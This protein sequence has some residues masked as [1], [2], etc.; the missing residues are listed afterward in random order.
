MNFKN[1]KKY[2]TKKN[3]LIVVATLAA[4]NIAR[5]GFDKLT[6]LGRDRRVFIYPVA[7]SRWNHKEV[8]YLNKEPVQ[9]KIQYYVDELVLGPSFYRGRPLFTP[10]TRVD[11]CFSDGKTLFVG[12]SSEAV[13]QEQGAVSIAE[14]KKLFKKNIKKNFS[15]IRH[16]EFFIGGVFI[17]D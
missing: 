7:G 17:E 8:R 10:G 4:F 1:Y 13:L 12:L 15:G 16:I 6:H 9:G 11:Y 5:V 2:L 14:A 3:I